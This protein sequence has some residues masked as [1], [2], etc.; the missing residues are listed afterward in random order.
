MTCIVKERELPSIE[1]KNREGGMFIRS[2][3]QSN[4]LLKPSPETPDMLSVLLKMTT[5]K[6]KVQVFS[7]SI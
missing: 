3:N 4:Q 7:I 2:L 5:S 6:I 1:L